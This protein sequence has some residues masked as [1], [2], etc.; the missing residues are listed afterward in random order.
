MKSKIAILLLLAAQWSSAQLLAEKSKNYTR[1]DSL[2]GSITPERAWWDLRH[3]NLKVTVDPE[4]RFISGANT[5]RYKVVTEGMQVMQID[6]QAPLTLERVEQ[7][8]QKLEVKSDGN[9]HFV[10]LK[11]KQ[12]AGKTYEV[13]VHYSGNPVVAK[14]APWD[15]GFSWSKD[16][17]GK[18]F[19]ATSC[20]GL[21]ASVWW[22]CK[23]HMYDENDEGMSMS[24]TVPSD[25]V[26]VGNGRLK[27]TKKNKDNTTTY[28]WAVVNP[29]NNYGVNFSAADY[30]TWTEKYVGEKGN[31]DMV[32]YVLRDNLT[33]AKTHFADARR[34][35]QAFEHWFGPYPFYEDS[36]KLVEVPYLGMEHQSAVTYGNGYVNGYRGMDLSQSGWGLKWDYIIVHETGHEW[37]AN[38][39]TYKDIADMWVHESFTMYSEALFVEYFYGKEAAYEYVRGVRRGINNLGTIIGDYEV[40]VEGQDLYNKGANMLHTIRQVVRDDDKWRSILRGLNKDFYHQTVTTAQIENYISEKAGRDLSPVFD[41]YLRDTRIP[42]F[43]YYEQNGRLIYR[44]TQVVGGFDMPLDIE[45]DGVWKRIKPTGI[46]AVSDFP[47]KGGLTISPDYYIYSNELRIK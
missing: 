16:K 5:I 45:V 15:G 38:N 19:V 39:I 10:Q 4:K 43:E 12:V 7:N 26:A 18:H 1:Q 41:Q 24:F 46:W 6:L 44:W 33:K 8:G 31:L 28:T 2:R 21:G 30:V 27:E 42:V 36:Y 37:F 3:Y 47:F 25:L 11:E 32:F 13:T 20:Q 22:P 40:N 35:M 23:D 29:I 17:N 14:N 9:A 34:T